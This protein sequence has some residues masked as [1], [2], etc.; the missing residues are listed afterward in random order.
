MGMSIA[1]AGEMMKSFVDEIQREKERQQ[2][3]KYFNLLA[4]K[5]WNPAL[6]F[7]DKRISGKPKV[8]R[9]NKVFYLLKPGMEN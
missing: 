5:R 4:R 7:Y 1:P 9:M 2:N 8:T 3:Q 6:M